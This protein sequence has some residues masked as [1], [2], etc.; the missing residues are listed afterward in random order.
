[1]T[2]A[3]DGRMSFSEF[4]L[5]GGDGLYRTA[6]LLTK[7]P[8]LAHD[9]VQEALLKAWRSWDRITDEPGGYVRTILV[10]E[11]LSG[12]RRRWHGEHAT[13][14][15]PEQHGST[16]TIGP[17]GPT[18]SGRPDVATRLTLA[19]AVRELPP[20]QRAVVVLRYFHDLTEADT[21]RILGLTVGT[22]KSHHSRA[23]AALRI[24]EHLA[25]DEVPATEGRGR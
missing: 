22:V 11:F 4:V 1:M 16:G 3:A 6:V 23:L 17:V 5:A 10:R 18:T 25:D 24:N 12:R 2:M 20:Q 19:D 9:L 21:A 13:E 8:H 15:L 7:D 14:H